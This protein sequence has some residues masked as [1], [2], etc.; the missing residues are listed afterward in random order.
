MLN[1]AILPADP[2]R[3][4]LSIRNL[5]STLLSPSSSPSSSPLSP[6]LTIHASLT[7]SVTALIWL[8]NIKQANTSLEL[9]TLLS[10]PAGGSIK[11]IQMPMTGIDD[12][13]ALI[14]STSQKITWSCAKGCCATLV[15][16][17]ALALALSLLRGLSKTGCM[18]SCE[19]ASLSGKSVVVIGN[20]GVG[21]QINRFLLPFACQVTMTD[22]I[23][24]KAQ[25]LQLLQ[26]VSLVFIACPLT[27][28]TK[29]MFAHEALSAMRSDAVLINVARGEIVNTGALINAV[30]H[31]NLNAA[32]LDVITFTH[33]KQG[34]KEKEEL[35]KLVKQGKLLIT[36]HAAIPHHMIEA[37]LGE[38]IRHN[39]EVLATGKG[40]LMGVV[41]P[42][43]GY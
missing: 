13:I 15:A 4:C 41:D 2:T 11:F 33:G 20:G 36:P 24:T 40:E 21:K 14:R 31:G 30:K 34:E 9:S 22:S 6:H 42:N 18:T 19:V 26:K 27:E 38:R 37:L 29:G 10:S 12:F 5:T 16:E 35:D 7:P 28:A 32:G 3:T 1:V 39:L 17:H 43:K 25:L 8:P 23:T